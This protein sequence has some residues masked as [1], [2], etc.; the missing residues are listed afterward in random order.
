[1]GSAP[2]YQMQTHFLVSGSRI[3]AKCS[4]CILSQDKIF[5]TGKSPPHD[6]YDGSLFKLSSKIKLFKLLPPDPWQIFRGILAYDKDAVTKL[7]RTSLQVGSA[8]PRRFKESPCRSAKLIH[9]SSEE[10]S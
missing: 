9:E 8:N 5:Q 7:G 2:L 1:M 10:L 3:D 6:F 4:I